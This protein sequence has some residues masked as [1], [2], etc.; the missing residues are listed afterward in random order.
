MEAVLR[1]ALLFAKGKPIGPDHLTI[2][3]SSMAALPAAETA[4]ALPS[5]P[6]DVAHRNLVV[7]TLKK[8]GLDKEEAAKEL[9]V[10]LRTSTR[11][12]RSTAFRRRR[13]FSLNILGCPRNPRA[14]TS[15]LS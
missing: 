14:W 12:W 9:K 11:G 6:E 5:S 1:N 15:S 2:K 13:R 7:A 10:S 3:A 8:H 4:P